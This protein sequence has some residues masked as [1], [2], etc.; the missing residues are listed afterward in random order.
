MGSITTKEAAYLTTAIIHTLV[1]FA[2]GILGLLLGFYRP[3]KSNAYLLAKLRRLR[4][5]IIVIGLAAGAYAIGYWYLLENTGTFDRG[6]AVTE[7]AGYVARLLLVL[8]IVW[9]LMESLFA[10]LAASLIVSATSVFAFLALVF[11]NFLT[12]D[13]QYGIVIAQF[14]FFWASMVIL[15]LIWNLVGRNKFYLQYVAI[16]V[17]GFLTALY[18]I[19]AS[20]SDN[21]FDVSGFNNDAENWTIVANDILLTASSIILIPLAYIYSTPSKDTALW[22]QYQRTRAST[23][24]KEQRREGLLEGTGRVLNL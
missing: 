13:T 12:T 15:S 10:K 16:A 1:F 4:Y 21:M 2:A 11:C 18:I 23:G 8:G 20:L 17:F 3:L 9:A 24:K 14:I 19:W 5:I 6:D 22:K 7:W